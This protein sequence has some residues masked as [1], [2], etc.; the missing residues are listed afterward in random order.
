MTGI[1]NTARLRARAAITATGTVGRTCPACGGPW[2][3]GYTYKHVDTCPIRDATD[4]THAADVAGMW[5]YPGGFTRLPTATELALAQAMGW[6]LPSGQT[7]V[8]V[9]K[10][11]TGAGAILRRVLMVR[12]R[13]DTA[14]QPEGPLTI[15]LSWLPTVCIVPSVDPDLA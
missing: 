7:V 9:V 4:T 6:T 8:M 2:L 10:P 13:P 15:D 12:D 3:Y 14:W 5:W 1:T 11:H